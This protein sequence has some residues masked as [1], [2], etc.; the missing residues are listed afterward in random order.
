MIKPLMRMRHR[1]RELLNAFT[2]RPTADCGEY[3]QAAG[4]DAEGLVSV[5]TLWDDVNFGRSHHS[6]LLHG[7]SDLWTVQ[8]LACFRRV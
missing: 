1:L 4:A 3:R 7:T 2:R 8:S 6:S 5:Q